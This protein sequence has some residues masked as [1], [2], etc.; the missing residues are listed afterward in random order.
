MVHPVR[1][2]V[3][4]MNHAAASLGDTAAAELRAY[5]ARRDLT[6][7]DA[8]DLVGVHPSWLA[9]R[10]R[11]STKLTLEDVEL[12]CTRLDIPISDV[13]RAA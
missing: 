10:L 7:D 13:V 8:A 3:Q 1:S 6:I 4:F 11:G 9:R 5:L 2:M 12:I